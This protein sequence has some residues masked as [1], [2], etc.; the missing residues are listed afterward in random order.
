MRQLS[1]VELFTIWDIVPVLKYT[2]GLT[3]TRKIL[4]VLNNHSYLE[5]IQDILPVLNYHANLLITRKILLCL[6]ITLALTLALTNSYDM[7]HL[8]RAELY[9]W[10]RHDLNH[11]TRAELSLIE[12]DWASL[13]LWIL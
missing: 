3:M 11:L 1:C 2:Y 6:I 13:A 8:A 4:P 12:S 5:L 10:L 9:F 7:K